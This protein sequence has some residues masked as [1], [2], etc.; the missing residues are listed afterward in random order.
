MPVVEQLRRSW[1]SAQ[2]TAMTQHSEL[3][4]QEVAARL[5]EVREKARRVFGSEEDVEAWLFRPAQSFGSR[6]PVAVLQDPEG[7]ELVRVLLGR[8]EYC[9][10]RLH[11]ACSNTTGAAK[12]SFP[13]VGPAAQ[14]LSSS[15]T[16]AHARG[17]VSPRHTVAGFQRRRE[18]ER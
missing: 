16:H 1:N 14:A 2:L 8:M 4:A 17:S 9:V 10:L 3:S 13:C 6:A 18:A 11:V 7:V 15:A 5:R 12:M